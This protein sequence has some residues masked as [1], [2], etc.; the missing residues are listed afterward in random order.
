MQGH[1]KQNKTKQINN[2]K[3]QD[4]SLDGKVKGGEGGIIHL[5][6]TVFV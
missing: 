5:L 3:K 2:H 6:Y 1:S 4:S